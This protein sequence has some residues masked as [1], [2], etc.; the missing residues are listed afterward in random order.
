MVHHFE[1]RNA[2]AGL[3]CVIVLGDSFR[4]DTTDLVPPPEIP[5]LPMPTVYNLTRDSGYSI[6][7]TNLPFEKETYEKPKPKIPFYAPFQKGRY[8]K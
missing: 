1:R 2:L 4:V 5:E 8:R 7:A 3:S 6:N